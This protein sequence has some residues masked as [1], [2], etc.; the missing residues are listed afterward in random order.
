VDEGKLLGCVTDAEV[1]CGIDAM[2]S[3]GGPFVC[4]RMVPIV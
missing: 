2:M 1:V 3:L 4:R